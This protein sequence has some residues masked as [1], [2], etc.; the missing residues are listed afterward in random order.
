MLRKLY[1]YTMRKLQNNPFDNMEGGE[2]DEKQGSKFFY[3]YLILLFVL[4]GIPL[5]IFYFK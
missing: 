3:L 5:V 1:F 4:I 2:I